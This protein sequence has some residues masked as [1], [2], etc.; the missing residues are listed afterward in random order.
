[1]PKRRLMAEALVL[2]DTLVERMKS[3][4]GVI[5]CEPAGSLRRRSETVGDLDILVSADAKDAHAIHEAFVTAPDVV[6]VLARGDSKSSV[7]TGGGLQADLRVVPPE[8]WGAAL[9]YFT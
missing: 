4:P 2:A 8:S 9:Q 3:V 7:V 6:E 5:A 1:E